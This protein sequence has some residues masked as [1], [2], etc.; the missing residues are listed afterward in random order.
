MHEHYP[1]LALTCCIPDWTIFRPSTSFSPSV[2]TSQSATGNDNNLRSMP[3]SRNWRRIG[4]QTSHGRLGWARIV[5]MTLDSHER[6]ALE[7]RIDALS[8]QL[9]QLLDEPSSSA[10]GAKSLAL[11]L[12]MGDLIR[13]IAREDEKPAP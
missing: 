11:Q 8:E 1:A 12:E 4:S 9:K 10:Q 13:T 2:P 3:A 6:E 5:Q 7:R